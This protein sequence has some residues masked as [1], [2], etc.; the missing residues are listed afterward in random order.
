MAK[1]SATEC[2]GILDVCKSL[3]AIS[4][5]RYEQ[6]RRLL[7]RI[8]SMLIKMAQIADHSGTGTHTGTSAIFS[9]KNL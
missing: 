6:S 5:L 3:K 9:E 8:V 4:E 1:R 7:L 2:A